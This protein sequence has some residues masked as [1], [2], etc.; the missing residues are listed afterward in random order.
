MENYTL[1]RCSK[2]NGKE[3]S[4]IKYMLYT[5]GEYSLANGDHDA[6]AEISPLITK[7]LS[8]VKSTHN[9]GVLSTKPSQEYMTL[10]IGDKRTAT[11]KLEEL[12]DEE[13]KQ[14]ESLI[15]EAEK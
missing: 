12:L 10:N 8:Y 13:K 11:F 9:V 14:V 15:I 6:H 2:I 1:A 7:Y 4:S 5:L 3:C